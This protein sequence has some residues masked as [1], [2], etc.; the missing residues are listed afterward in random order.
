MLIVVMRGKSW[1]TTRTP[2]EPPSKPRKRG[3]R[4]ANRNPYRGNKDPFAGNREALAK[5]FKRAGMDFPEIKEAFDRLD[6]LIEAQ[7]GG[8][9]NRRVGGRYVQTQLGTSD[10]RIPEEN[11]PDQGLKGPTFE[12][13][14]LK[15]LKGAADKLKGIANRMVE[16]EVS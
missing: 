13:K 2:D 1:G 15:F 14:T 7:H 9:V 3:R 6:R 12:E 4:M 10:A 16:K 5:S 8:K 11:Y